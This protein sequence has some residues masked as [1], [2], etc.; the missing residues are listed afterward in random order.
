[1]FDIAHPDAVVK[2]AF[3]QIMANGAQLL[4]FKEYRVYAP[5]LLPT[6]KGNASI[7]PPIDFPKRSCFLS[8]TI[9]VFLSIPPRKFIGFL[10]TSKEPFAFPRTITLTF[11]L[12]LPVLFF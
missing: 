9:P 2:S 1:M 3:R 4:Y 10:A 8:C 12:F 7:L 11:I 6:P 5:T